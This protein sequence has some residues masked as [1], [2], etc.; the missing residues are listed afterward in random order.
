[1]LVAPLVVSVPPLTM[2]P[3]SLLKLPFTVRL[4]PLT[5]SD[6]P[7]TAR[8][9]MVWSPLPR[10]TALPPPSWLMLTSLL[11]TG[12]LLV[13]QLMALV[14]WLSPASLSQYSAPL[15]PPAVWYR[16]SALPV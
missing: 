10:N 1:M 5:H 7:V 11:A 15:P 6:L 8:L 12:R 3:R 16:L 13:L 4:P 14:H 2:T 9:W